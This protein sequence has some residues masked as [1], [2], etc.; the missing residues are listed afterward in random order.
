MHTT[1]KKGKQIK[2]ELWSIFEEAVG[3]K[4][5]ECIYQKSGERECCDV[6]KSALRVTDEGYFACSNTKCSIVYTDILDT[7][8]EWRYYGGDDNQSSDPTRCGMPVNPLLKE[9][10]YGCK[11]LCGARD[12]YEMKKI[13]KY[14]EWQSMPYKEKSQYDEF[15]RITI[16]AQNAGISKMI[17]NDAMIYY[18]KISEHK[19]FRGLNRDGIIS[20]SIYIACRINSNPRTAKEIAKIFTLD[21]TSATKG[22]KNALTIVNELESDMHN[23]EKTNLTN[24]RPEIFIERYC[25]KL[26][27]NKEL[28]K[29]CCFIAIKVFKQNMIPENTPHS[30]TAGIIYFISQICNLNINK[31]DIWVTTGISEVTTNKCYK[32]LEQ[33]KDQLLPSAIIAKYTNSE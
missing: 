24:L 18:K 23:N 22:C 33:Y 28:T 9:S 31:K 6:C 15:Q 14:T 20:A 32:K 12:S 5:V 21:N 10:S 2:Q 16:I 4:T 30:C 1:K 11:V 17:I 13:R 29:L 26:H 3:N 27:I 8:P 7:N 19:T 25:S